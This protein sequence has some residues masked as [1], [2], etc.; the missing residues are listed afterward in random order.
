MLIN[1]LIKM[2]L[3]FLAVGRFLPRDILVAHSRKPSTV[4]KICSSSVHLKIPL[5][6]DLLHYNLYARNRGEMSSK[7]KNNHGHLSFAVAVSKHIT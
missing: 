6:F 1:L 2:S 7:I 4:L 5:A 3:L